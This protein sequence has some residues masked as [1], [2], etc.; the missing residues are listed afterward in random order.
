MVF[1]DRDGTLTE[2]VG[3]VN[4]PSRLRLLPQS[5]AA[6]RRLNQAC[7]A[8]VLV[9]NQQEGAYLDGIA[10]FPVPPDRVADDL[11]DA[12]GWVLSG[13]SP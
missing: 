3:Y 9:T 2:E 1:V 7:I 12:V 11:F 6:I 5:A 13:R 8:A 4:H 10:T